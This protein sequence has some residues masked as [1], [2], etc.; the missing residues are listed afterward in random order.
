MLQR[1]VNMPIPAGSPAR[2]SEPEQNAH[3]ERQYE[4][5][6]AIRDRLHRRRLIISVVLQ[7]HK[8]ISVLSFEEG[9]YKHE[10]LK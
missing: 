2:V 5:A 4:E 9:I 8:G 1:Y 7:G 6:V 3:T 10:S